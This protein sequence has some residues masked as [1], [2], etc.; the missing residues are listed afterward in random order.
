MEPDERIIQSLVLEDEVLKFKD[1]DGTEITTFDLKDKNFG[2]LKNDP[3][4]PGLSGYKFRTSANTDKSRL[5][6]MQLPGFLIIDDKKYNILESQKPQ[7]SLILSGRVHTQGLSSFF[8]GYRRK[9]RKTRDRRHTRKQRKT[10]S[11]KI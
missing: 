6:Q 1:G 9:S 8:G 5:I 10:R 4:Y 7:L 3:K 2:F 11:R